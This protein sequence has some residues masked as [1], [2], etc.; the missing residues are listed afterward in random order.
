[1]AEAEE[2]DGRH[3]QATSVH[4]RGVSP[5]G[6]GRHPPRGRP[7]RA[8]RG[9]DHRDGADSEPQPDVTLLA[10]CSDFYASA[11]PEPPDVRLLIEVADP[12]LAYDRRRKFPL[13]ARARVVEAW[14]VDLP[15]TRVEIHRGPGEAGYRSVSTPGDEERFAPLA[16][17]DLTVTVRDLRG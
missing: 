9:R 14:L 6:R 15:A 1:M 12:S 11:L 3:G 13:Y 7:C 17:A 10:H 4:A 5:H 2:A 16:F 8:D